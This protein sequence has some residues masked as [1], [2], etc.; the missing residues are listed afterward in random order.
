MPF[1]IDRIRKEK[2]LVLNIIE[3]WDENG[4]PVAVMQ[5]ARADEDPPQWGE[6]ALLCGCNLKPGNVT[7]H[8]VVGSDPDVC[9]QRQAVHKR[10][11]ARAIAR[12]PEWKSMNLGNAILDIFGRV[13]ANEYLGQVV[14]GVIYTQEVAVLL[15]R[16]HDRVLAEVFRLRDEERVDLNGRILIPYEPRFRFP[17][18]L[19]DMIAM[20]VID[21]FGAPNGDADQA[22]VAELEAYVTEHGHFTHGRDAFGPFWP[23][24]PL[25][26]L[27]LPGE[28]WVANAVCPC[29]V[30]GANSLEPAGKAILDAIKQFQLYSD[31]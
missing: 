2:E 27:S 8:R 15:E 31:A 29:L 24:I 17:V 21:L 13:Q 25:E 3:E 26:V 28:N 4:H 10:V 14:S 18:E 22:V 5:L 9:P 11:I 20:A 7:Q 19:E 23:H 30:K 6:V 1:D 12:H 16:D